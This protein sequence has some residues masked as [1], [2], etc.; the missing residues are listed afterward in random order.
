M[1]YFKLKMKVWNFSI[2][3]IES[4]AIILIWILIITD[5]I[6]GD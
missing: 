1:N 5:C 4:V 2:A 3:F 6:I